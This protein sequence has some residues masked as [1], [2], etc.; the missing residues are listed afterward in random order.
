MLQRHQN[1]RFYWKIKRIG[2]LSWLKTFFNTIC[3]LFV[4]VPFI[5]HQVHILQIWCLW[6]NRTHQRNVPFIWEQ[7]EKNYLETIHPFNDIFEYAVLQHQWLF[8][9]H[10]NFLDFPPN[11]IIEVGLSKH[12]NNTNKLVHNMKKNKVH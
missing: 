12:N 5:D 8:Y 7:N 4:F 2:S 11:A 6:N 10:R 1:T 3:N 9:C